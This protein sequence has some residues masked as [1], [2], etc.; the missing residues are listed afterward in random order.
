M[1]SFDQMHVLFFYTEKLNKIFS[2]I[3]GICLCQV[4]EQ[5]RQILQYS[6]LCCLGKP[7]TVCSA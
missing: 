3:Y 4:E 5:F 6:Q 2:E 7:R 1:G